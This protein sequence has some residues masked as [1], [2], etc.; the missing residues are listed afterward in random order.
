[1]AL[2]LIV[3]CTTK[4]EVVSADG[5]T[6]CYDV[7]GNGT[8]AL[9]FVHG[10]CCDKTYW[11]EQVPHF[12]KQYKVVTIDLAGHG[13]SGLGR[14]TFTMET[15]GEDVVAVVEE[16]DLDEVVLIGHSMGG[17]VILEAARRMPGCVIGLVGADT[18]RSVE[19][20][21]Q[22]DR[23]LSALRANFS[24]AAENFVRIMFLPTAD[25]TL[26]ATIA[27]DMSAAPPQ[28]GVRAFEEL[29]LYS[30]TELTRAL[31]Q[32]QAPIRC[33]NSNIWP[34]DVEAGK[35]HATS[36]EMEIMSGVGH[37]VM[38]EDPET[39]NRLLDQTITEFVQ[40]SEK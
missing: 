39:F 38:I 27:S 12:S 22:N 26:I 4:N 21:F 37:F 30:N 7:Q 13:E 25:S 11:E 9:V 2:S 16:L 29:V 20:K 24:E 31:Q 14:E 33:I 3:N 8:P 1:M 36:F 18:Y 19:A 32:V 34:N 6:I 23:L 5:V 17:A 28:I 40:L 35:R 10:W 15:F